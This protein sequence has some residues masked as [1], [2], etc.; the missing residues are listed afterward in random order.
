MPT[1]RFARFT[2]LGRSPVP[3]AGEAVLVQSQSGRVCCEFSLNILHVVSFSSSQHALQVDLRQRADV[4]VWPA[5]QT[6]VTLRAIIKGHPNFLWRNTMQGFPPL[7]LYTCHVTINSASNH[8]VTINCK[9]RAAVAV[10]YS[11]LQQQSC[12]RQEPIYI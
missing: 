4:R 12:C 3:I 2:A 7:H 9:P 10:T 8:W 6:Q 5:P 1:S 11:H